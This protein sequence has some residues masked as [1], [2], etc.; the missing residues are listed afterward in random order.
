MTYNLI[1]LTAVRNAVDDPDVRD[2]AGLDSIDDDDL[3]EIAARLDRLDRETDV[4]AH[5]AG[6]RDLNRWI[7]DNV[8]ELDAFLTGVR[9]MP[10][11]DALKE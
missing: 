7:A 8:P 5:I 1:T 3:D 9:T 10:G 2:R 11:M 4:A 6:V